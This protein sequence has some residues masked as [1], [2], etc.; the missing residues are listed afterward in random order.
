MKKLLISL[1]TI[2]ITIGLI[3]LGIS[4]NLKRTISN[5]TST[6]IKEE[7]TNTMTTYLENNTSVDKEEIKKGV[8]KVL[9]SNDTLKKTI[10][11]YY[12][13]I[14]NVLG[15]KDAKE[16][17]V[18]SELET[19]IDNSEEILKE[20]GVTISKQDKEKLMEIV[21]NDEIN[22]TVNE[23]IKE[24]KSD[25]PKEVTEV[26][27][28][29]NFI[30]G[31]TFKII[32]ISVIILFLVVIALLKKSTYKWLIN[33]GI[34]SI[35]TGLLYSFVLP[36]LMDIITKSLNDNIS[37]SL[38]SMVNYGYIV[39]ILGVIAVILNIV[40]NKIFNKELS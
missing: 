34:A 18:A 1:L 15:N 28:I 7:V 33:F 32:L 19:L 6:I 27:N 20:Y 2:F 38:S 30:S 21:S 23:A 16:I 22:K 3:L 40:L 24:I 8:D 36:N 4:L 5:V 25:M 12:D 39:L 11:N 29:L 9:N 35:I 31:T 10:D 13:E 17:N 14:I 26:I 37:I